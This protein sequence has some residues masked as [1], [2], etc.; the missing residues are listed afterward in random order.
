MTGYLELF[1]WFVYLLYYC[2]YCL[3]VPVLDPKPKNG[4]GIVHLCPW[5][6][7]GTSV[8]LDYMTLPGSVQPIVLL[9]AQF[10][11]GTLGGVRSGICEGFHEN[12]GGTLDINHHPA[13]PIPCQSQEE[14]VELPG[15]LV[16]SPSPGPIG[17]YM[18]DQD[19][20]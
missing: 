18:A 13:R 7:F 5:P 10:L 12:S 8:V 4:K 16:S 15:V 17:S 14:A 2:T 9:N 20:T 1:Y 19:V 6:S 11:R 3:N